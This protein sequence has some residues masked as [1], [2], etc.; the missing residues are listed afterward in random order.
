MSDPLPGWRNLGEFMFSR[1][2]A[3]IAAMALLFAPV[4]AQAARVSPMIVELRPAGGGSVARVELTNPGERDIP[5]EARVMRGEISETGE[6]TLT[7]ADDQFLV[8]PAQTIVQKNSQQVFRLQY[9]GAPDLEKSEIYYLSIQQ[10]PVK[11]EPG[12]S[13]V[14]V[15]INYNV[16]VNVVP[17]GTAPQAVIASVEPTVRLP[18][19]PPEEAAPVPAAPDPAKPGDPAAPAAPAATS[20]VLSAPVPQPGIRV[21]VTNSGTR[22]FL[23]GMSKWTINGTTVAG[24]PYSRSYRGEE[25]TRIIGVGVIGPDR[26]RSFFVPTDE[27]LAAES[28][29][30][31]VSP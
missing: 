29:R 3:A 30:V 11:F 21:R 22:Y 31:E 18:E 26:T 14:Q 10:V 7:P 5:F 27:P 16:L 1:F 20:A 19:P 8:F 17:N 13:Q 4:A 12:Q 23:A 28:I 9:V 2:T 25:M 15:V 6:L 24:A